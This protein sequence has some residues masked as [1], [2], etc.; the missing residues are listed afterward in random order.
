MTSRSVCNQ[1]DHCDYKTNSRGTLFT[2]VKSK[3]EGVKFPCD[4][5]DYKA[6]LKGNLLKHVE[7]KHEAVKFPC[8]QCKYKASFKANLL[9]HIKARHEGVKFPCD[10]CDYEEVF[11]D[12]YKCK[13]RTRSQV[14]LWPMWL[15]SNTEEVFIDSYKCKTRTTQVSFMNES[16]FLVFNVIIRQLVRKIYWIISNQ[17]MKE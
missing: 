14:Y 10:Q 12:S 11:I 8:D 17:V 13:T 16:S 1:C 6:T 9:S 2:H 4:Q 15:R 5:C 7:A 3:H